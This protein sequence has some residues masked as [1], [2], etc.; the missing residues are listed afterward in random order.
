MSIL[1]QTPKNMNKDFIIEAIGWYGMMAI[2][3]AYLLVSFN[4]LSVGDIF[5][6][7]LNF[8]GAAGVAYISFKKKARQP[9]VL[10]IIWAV[11]ALAALLNP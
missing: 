8:T 11:I 4:F 9:A 7:V 1:D 6:Q 10:N 2:L 5:Y 3:L